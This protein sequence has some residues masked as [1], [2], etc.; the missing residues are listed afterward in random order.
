MAKML[1]LMG[2]AICGNDSRNGQLFRWT[3]H[4]GKTPTKL[5]TRVLFA[6]HNCEQYLDEFTAKIDEEKE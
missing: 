1:D 2:C 4:P 3:Q 6:C 5:P